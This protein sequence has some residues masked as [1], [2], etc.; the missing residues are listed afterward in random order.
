MYKA[1]LWKLN[2]QNKKET[3]MSTE[4]REIRARSFILVDEN[5]KELAALDATPSGPELWMCE[6]NGKSRAMLT[7][8]KGGPK[9]TLYD[10][11]GKPRALLA[12]TKD[13]PGLM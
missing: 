2:I 5:G 12:G 9:L 10:D 8:F 6:E 1:T 11:N 4:E 7:V 3:I 13:G